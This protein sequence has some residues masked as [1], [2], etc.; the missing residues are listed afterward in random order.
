MR[1]FIILNQQ[2]IFGDENI[3]VGEKYVPLSLINELLWSEK[4]RKLSPFHPAI[5]CRNLA[6]CPISRG[7]GLALSWFDAQALK[8]P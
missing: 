6:H 2:K 8:L 7:D 5:N 3:K 4:N 1:K